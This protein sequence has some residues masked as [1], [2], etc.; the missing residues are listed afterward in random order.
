MKYG[1]V[2]T[3]WKVHCTFRESKRAS[4]LILSAPG[5]NPSVVWPSWFSQRAHKETKFNLESWSD[6]HCY[7]LRIQLCLKRGELDSSEK[8]HHIQD[9]LESYTRALLVCCDNR[10]FI[11]HAHMHRHAVAH[12][13]TCTPS[14]PCTHIIFLSTTETLTC[15]HTVSA[16]WDLITEQTLSNRLPL[17]T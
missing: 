2:S 15:A 13:H 12:E 11:T 1:G 4:A 7:V 3:G 10:L 16:A 14:L 6:P 17:R 5:I 8:K 9:W